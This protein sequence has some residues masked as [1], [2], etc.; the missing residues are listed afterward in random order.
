MENVA[1]S[2]N[3]PKYFFSAAL[4]RKVAYLLFSETMTF[5]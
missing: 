5:L 1:I 2:S 4:W 3:F